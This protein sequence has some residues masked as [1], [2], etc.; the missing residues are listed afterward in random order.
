MACKLPLYTCLVE[1]VVR[2]RWVWLVVILGASVLFAWQLGGLVLDGSV[3][4]ILLKDDPERP[5][6]ARAAELFGSDEIIA[7]VLSYEEGVW[8]PDVLRQLDDL[9]QRLMRLEHVVH[10]DSLAN[11]A[12]VTGTFGLVRTATILERAQ[13]GAPLD[14]LRRKAWDDPLVRRNLVS[15][16]G[17]VTAIN[18]R[19]D[20]IRETPGI[21]PKLTGEIRRILDE[22]V[23]PNRYHLTGW[24]VVQAE[25]TNYMLRDLSTLLPL[26]ALVVTLLL[27]LI[28]RRLAGVALPLAAIG[29]AI[30]WTMGGLVA[31]GRSV[32]MVT[33]SLPVIIIAIG[34]TY[35]I[36]VLT[37]I[38]RLLDESGDRRQA[39]RAALQSTG[40]GVLLCG[41]TTMIGFSALKLS[42][43]EAIDEFGTFAVWGVLASTLMALVFLPAAVLV[44]PLRSRT[45]HWRGARLPSAAT[46]LT[47]LLERRRTVWAVTALVLAISAVGIMRIRVETAPLAWFPEDSDVRVSVDYVNRNLAGITPY[48]LIVETGRAGRVYDPDFLGKIEQF[49][50][51]LEQQPEVDTTISLADPVTSA[52]QAAGRGRRIPPTRAAIERTVAQART[53]ALPGLDT[54]VT[55]DGSAANI[56]IRSQV[57]SSER[58][59]AFAERVDRRAAA[60]FGDG[61]RAKITGSAHLAYRT[62]TQFTSGLLRSLAISLAAVCLIMIVA[63]RSWRLGLLAIVPN[64]IPIGINYAIL[65]LGDLTLNAGTSITGCIAIGMAVDDTIHFLMIFRHGLNMGG[66]KHMALEH[67]LRHVGRPMVT[68]SVSLLAGFS[69]LMFSN[70][71]PIASLGMLVAATM[72]ACLVCDLVLLPVLLTVSV[73]A[74]RLPGCRR[75]PVVARALP[76]Q[77]SPAAVVAQQESFPTRGCVGPRPG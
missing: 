43:V 76:S 44:L 23:G 10:V 56:V 16:S 15:A 46:L 12:L 73:P 49:Q 47:A 65:G 3:E 52:S 55:R 25:I 48:H 11:H 30:L 61:A 58:G 21:K 42:P 24:P 60:Q 22:H 37:H 1:A 33:N 27:L 20:S 7:A 66:G 31:S 36:H 19:L 70:F 53:R 72:V 28:F 29:L 4:R 2:L 64:V 8:R 45:C 68:T 38:F 62:N 18:V 75:R 77:D 67:T 6:H 13:R 69:V 57:L 26:T 51:W 39:V 50:R 40:R 14:D 34:T 17:R 74:L 71:S 54:L 41:I 9:S 59:L 5:D 32:S 35:C 63:F